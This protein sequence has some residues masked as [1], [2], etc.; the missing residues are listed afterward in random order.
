MSEGSRFYEA[1]ETLRR[2]RCHRRIHLLLALAEELLGAALLQHAPARI[3]DFMAE[4][5][6]GIPEPTK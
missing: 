2:R 5:P 4:I 6:Q 1:L 3:Q